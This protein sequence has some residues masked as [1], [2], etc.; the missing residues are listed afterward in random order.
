MFLNAATDITLLKIVVTLSVFFLTFLFITTEKL[1]NAIAAMAGA[2]ILIIFHVV[3]QEEAIDYVDF[4]TIGLLC[5]MMLTV[6]VMRKTGLFEYIAI[7]GIKMTGGNPWK[8]LV[9]LSIVTAV[10]SAFLDNVTTVLIIVPLTFAVC[11]TIRVNPTPILISEILFSNIGG[12]ATLIGDPPNI[13]IG[14]ATE[15]DFMDFIYNNLPIVIL[16]SIVTMGLLRLIYYKKL[17]E[18]PVDSKKILAFDERR[19]IPDK[20]FLISTLIVFGLIIIAFVTHQFHHISLASVAIGGGFTLMMVTRQDPEEVLKEVEWPTLFFF[21]GLFVIVGGLDKT[22]VIHKVAVSML[23]VTKGQEGP[24][25]QFVLWL[26]ALST[27]VVNSIP[28]TAT[29]ISLIENMSGSISGDIN[30]IWWALSLGACFGGNGTLV[31]A[32]ANIIVAGFT[33]KTKYPLRFGEYFKVA[34]PLMLVSVAMVSGYLY[35]KYTYF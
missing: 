18:I 3:S 1:P 34:F 16:V 28:F 24:S 11:E 30:N 12:A 31:G 2:F 32:A 15:L 4:D 25:T 5:G 17:M 9:V 33:Q 23:D 20:K 8:I 14:G 22:G 26:S 6:A 13:M 19:T 35:L 29:M 27:T 10:L 21:L 7:K